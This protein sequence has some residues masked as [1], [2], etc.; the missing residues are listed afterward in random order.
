MPV[1]WILWDVLPRTWK[2]TT[3]V[4]RCWSLLDDD[5]PLLERNG[6][7]DPQTLG[8]MIQFDGGAYSSNGW[9]ETP[10]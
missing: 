5:R 1:P 9:Q 10:S 8:E 4:K 7:F 2:S 6:G 3:I